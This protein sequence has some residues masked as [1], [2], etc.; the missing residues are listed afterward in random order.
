MRDRI[1]TPLGIMAIGAVVFAVVFAAAASLTVGTNLLPQAGSDVTLPCDANGVNVGYN[2]SLGSVT[3]M[4]V[5]GIDCATGTVT[6]VT[7]AGY[8]FVQT[9]TQN[10]ASS[11]TYTLGAAGGA[12]LPIAIAA[13]V[14][15]TVTVTLIP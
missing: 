5:S 10:T 9:A 3:G 2:V 4:V 8:T 12:A 1:R 15:G 14:P 13:F 6:L 7:T 11:L